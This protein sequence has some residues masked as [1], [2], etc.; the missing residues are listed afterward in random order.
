M[1]DFQLT[2]LEDY[3]RESKVTLKLSQTLEAE[4]GY[5]S[6]IKKQVCRTQIQFKLSSVLQNVEVFGSSILVMIHL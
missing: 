4:F 6:I 1:Q 3:G 2:R 5:T